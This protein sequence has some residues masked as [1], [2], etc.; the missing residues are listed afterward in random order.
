VKHGFVDQV[1]DYPWSSYK[2]IKTVKPTNIN[3]NVVLNYFDGVENFIA[4]HRMPLDAIEE[5]IEDLI[6][7]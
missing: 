5:S 1:D 2:I 3:R 7:E 4:T 6:I